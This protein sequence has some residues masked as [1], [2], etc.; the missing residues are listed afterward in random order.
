MICPKCGNSNQCPCTNCDPDCTKPNKYIWKDT[1][2]GFD[3]CHFF[4]S[5]FNELDSL[6][7]EWSLMVKGYKEK[8]NP[9]LC[10]FWFESKNKSDLHLAHGLDSFAFRMVFREYYQVDPQNLKMEDWL[11]IKRD[12]KLFKLIE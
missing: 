10:A 9:E 12:Y 11:V 4:G 2:N 6:D 1:K 3:Q 5:E 8:I 7:Y